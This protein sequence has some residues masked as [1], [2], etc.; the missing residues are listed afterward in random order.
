MPIIPGLGMISSLFRAHKKLPIWLKAICYFDSFFI[1]AII[2][3]LGTVLISPIAVIFN[4]YAHHSKGLGVVIIAHKV[5]LLDF[6]VI[7]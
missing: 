2:A 6:D 1:N 5:N 3:E 7:S 4:R